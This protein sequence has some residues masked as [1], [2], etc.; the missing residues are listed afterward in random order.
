[1]VNDLIKN[2]LH[3]GL[4]RNEVLLMLG[5]PN[6]EDGTGSHGTIDIYW[7]THP[8]SLWQDLL[9]WFRFQS[10]EPVLVLEYGTEEEKLID[11]RIK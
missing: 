1:M 5:R 4:K 2:H 9:T 8:R 7:L 3:K 11:I 10:K 6:T